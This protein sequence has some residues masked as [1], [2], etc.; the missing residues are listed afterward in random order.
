[1]RLIAAI[2]FKKGV[3]PLVIQLFSKSLEAACKRTHSRGTHRRGRHEQRLLHTSPDKLKAEEQD[4]LK[5]WLA[6]DPHPERLYNALQHMRTVYAAH[7]EESGKEA[8][9]QWI[10][11]HLTSPTAA[12]R[13]IA[14][15]VVQWRESIQNYFS[16]RV[17][18]APIEG[19]HNKVKVI[20]RRAYGY[21]NIERFKIRIRLECKPAM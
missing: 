16:F 15:T 6:Q 8:L 17:T 4:E 20:K 3:P 2:A 9:Q 1:M 14:K 12:I 18:N 11:E 5:V 21:R 19:T 13:S 10:A 7:T